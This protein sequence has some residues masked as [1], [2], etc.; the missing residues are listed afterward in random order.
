MPGKVSLSVVMRL[1]FLKEFKPVDL[2]C[3]RYCTEAAA[4]W[5]QTTYKLGGNPDIFHKI[6]NPPSSILGMGWSVDDEGKDVITQMG[7]PDSSDAWGTLL[8]MYGPLIIAVKL[9]PG[10]GHYVLVTGVDGETLE[11][12]DPLRG[13]TQLTKD[14]VQMTKT[15]NGTVV[16]AV[17]KLKLKAKLDA[18]PSG[19][20]DLP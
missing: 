15:I 7:I 20:V 4:K 8:K 18:T 17:S 19:L 13:D 14:R 6:L 1:Q 12:K 16:S 11:Y 9:A 2:N 3:G 5:I 10:C